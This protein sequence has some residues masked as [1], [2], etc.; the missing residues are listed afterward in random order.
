MTLRY[1]RSNSKLKKRVKIP[2]ASGSSLRLR[3]GAW[4]LFRRKQ[5][6]RTTRT[7]CIWWRMQRVTKNWSGDTNEINL[8]IRSSSL[9]K[10]MKFRN[11][12]LTWKVSIKCT[13]AWL[14]CKIQLRRPPSWENKSRQPRYRYRWWTWRW[15]YWLRVTKDSRRPGK[16]SSLRKM[17]Q[18]WSVRISGLKWRRRRTSLR[19][20]C[21]TNCRE[22][23]LKR[24][25]NFWLR[26]RSLARQMMICAPS[27]RKKSRSW[28]RC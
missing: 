11:L 21:R 27:C 16:S 19:S 25:K 3:C 14:S 9:R 13:R 2:S 26:R 12:M 18:S 4:T 1:A 20:V 28:I 17:K 5:P 15:R 24:R 23:R 6:L 7:R 8:W 10:M 22:I